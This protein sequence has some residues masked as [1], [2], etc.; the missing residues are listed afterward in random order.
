MNF[1]PI[2]WYVVHCVLYFLLQKNTR[3]LNQICRLC[4]S[5]SEFYLEN[6][7]LCTRLHAVAIATWNLCFSTKS[8]SLPVSLYNSLFTPGRPHPDRN[9]LQLT[10]KFKCFLNL[11]LKWHSFLVHIWLFVN[12]IEWLHIHV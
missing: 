8:Y 2:E 7:C 1:I 9:F 10:F 4:F 11:L 6:L 12:N 3:S 5:A